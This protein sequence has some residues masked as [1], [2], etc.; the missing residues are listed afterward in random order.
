MSINE[1]NQK[2]ISELLSIA[3]PNKYTKWYVSIIKSSTTKF[4]INPQVAIT[5]NKR[6]AKKQIG[7]IEGHHIIPK[8]I[9]PAY[10]DDNYNIAYLSPKE[11]F[12]VH[13]LL[14]KMFEGKCKSKM[15]FAFRRMNHGSPN[16]YKSKIY[17]L[18][19]ISMPAAN[20]GKINITNGTDTIHHDST[21][22]IPAGWYKGSGLLYKNNRQLINN[23]NHL[24]TFKITNINTGEYLIA[25]N[26][27]LWS[28]ENNIPYSTVISAVRLRTILRK[29]YIITK[30]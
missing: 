15:I 16:R 12:I 29:Q 24:R 10:A 30:L 8:S 26:I 5:Q 25:N 17:N 1:N 23:E 6:L 7:Y 14:T 3:I 21:I 2:Y 9:M 11:H 13:L 22:T 19:K 28:T 18:S 27:G 20:L 4:I